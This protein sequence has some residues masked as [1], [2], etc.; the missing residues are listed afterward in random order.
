MNLQ[1]SHSKICDRLGI[2]PAQLVEFCQQWHVAELSLFGSILRDDFRP[3]SDVDVLIKLDPDPNLH[4]SLMDL[5]ECN[6]NS[7]KWLGAKSICLKKSL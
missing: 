1:A 6:I 2:T 4:I 5:V 3:D 7:K